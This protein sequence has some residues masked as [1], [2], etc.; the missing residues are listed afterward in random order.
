M[1]KIIIAIATAWEWLKGKKTFVLGIMG[2]CGA[3]GNAAQAIT[4]GTI[5][6]SIPWIVLHLQ[7]VAPYYNYIL[8]WLA[9][10]TG[11]AAIPDG[12]QPLTIRIQAI[13][14]KLQKTPV[15]PPAK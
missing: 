7:T 15:L 4:S 3:I 6:L 2:L 10:L 9:V 12:Y 13:R 1:T 8:L 14:E 5:Q 11:R